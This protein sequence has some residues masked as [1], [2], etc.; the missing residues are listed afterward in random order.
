VAAKLAF[1]PGMVVGLI[2]F[3]KVCARDSDKLGQ[4]EKPIRRPLLLV[5]DSIGKV[6]T[7][8]RTTDT[9]AI[10]RYELSGCSQLSEGAHATLLD[11]SYIVRALFFSFPSVSAQISRARPRRSLTL[12]TIPKG[13]IRSIV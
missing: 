8:P 12:G 7:R 5:G 10:L 9:R 2:V 11:L 4:S 3:W 13:T 6:P 1:Y